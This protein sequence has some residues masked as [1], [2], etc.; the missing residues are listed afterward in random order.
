MRLFELRRRY[1]DSPPQ[2]K[3]EMC[4]S[5]GA[6]QELKNWQSFFRQYP[7]YTYEP[8]LYHLTDD[9]ALCC[10]CV[11]IANRKL[12]EMVVEELRTGD[13]DKNERSY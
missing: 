11:P 8:R 5:C 6:T 9:Y 7:R 13:K 4:R 12:R 1:W 10:I 3:P 2:E